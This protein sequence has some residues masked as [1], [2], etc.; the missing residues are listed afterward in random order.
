MVPNA[1]YRQRSRSQSKSKTDPKAQNESEKERKE[2]KEREERELREHRLFHASQARHI[3]TDS[4]SSI[5]PDLPSTLRADD[6]LAEFINPLARDDLFRRMVEREAQM[7]LGILQRCRDAGD[8]AS[9]SH[10]SQLAP[11]FSGNGPAEPTL[12]LSMDDDLP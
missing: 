11:L 2:R 4:L 5:N 8:F 7:R 1:Q 12:D 9:E 10:F 3:P 6:Y